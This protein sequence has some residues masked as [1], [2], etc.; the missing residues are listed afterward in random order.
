MLLWFQLPMED[1][2]PYGNLMDKN[3][4]RGPPAQ[5]SPMHMSPNVSPPQGAWPMAS[6]PMQNPS[7]VGLHGMS[8]QGHS[9]DSHG[10]SPQGISPL[11]HGA[12]MSS[13][14]GDMMMGPPSNSPP[15]MGYSPQHPHISPQH[16][17]SSPPR[18]VQ[19]IA[20]RPPVLG[21]LMVRACLT[22]AS[23]FIDV[24]VFPLLCC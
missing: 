16:M 6:M 19:S 11:H 8:P 7:P 20:P 23:L 24:L 12:N 2:N 9:P 22:L 3:Q 14:M 1:N 18:Q 17:V 15:Q 10:M 5:N 21:Q 13:S 4:F